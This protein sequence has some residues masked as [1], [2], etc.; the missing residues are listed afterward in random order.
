MQPKVH[1]TVLVLMAAIGLASSLDLL[2]E[3]VNVNSVVLLDNYGG[4]TIQVQEGQVVRKMFNPPIDPTTI[5]LSSDAVGWSRPSDPL[6]SHMIGRADFKALHPGV[7][8]IKYKI[9]DGWQSGPIYY[10]ADILVRDRGRPYDLALSANGMSSS[11]WTPSGF[12]L[13]VG[14]EV[15]VAS[16][17]GQVLTTDSSIVV[18]TVRLMLGNPGGLATLRAIRAGTAQIGIH[19]ADGFWLPAA[20]VVSNSASRFDL[21]A[22]EPDDGKVI[23]M[24]A[25]Q[26]LRLTL[27]NLPHYRPWY[28]ARQPEGVMLLVDPKSLG[29]D[30]NGVF[31]FQAIKSGTREILFRAEPASCSDQTCADQTRELHLNLRISS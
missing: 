30:A 16:P 6:A 28:I 24:G 27:T 20:I 17:D 4:H 23:H 11:F 29:Q 18:P 12:A 10:V 7:S 2:G 9:A 21:T 26:S 25:G 8:T 5:T 13:R 1:P 3:V 31:G 19:R 22:N 14:D 15:I